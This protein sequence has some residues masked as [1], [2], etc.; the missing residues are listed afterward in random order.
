VRTWLTY[1]LLNGP[2]PL[3][4]KVGRGESTGEAYDEAQQG[5]KTHLGEM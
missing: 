4:L 3:F 1:A 5:G 2:V